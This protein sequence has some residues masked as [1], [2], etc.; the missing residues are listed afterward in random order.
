VDATLFSEPEATMPK[1][2]PK[3]PSDA[4]LTTFL[5]TL[6]SWDGATPSFQDIV[7][8]AATHAGAIKERHGDD[9]AFIPDLASQTNLAESLIKKW[10]AG[11]SLPNAKLAKTVVNEIRIYLERRRIPPHER[12]N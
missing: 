6:A 11:K 2:K 7:I 8:D 4:E 9:T 3:G 1:G 10:V 12:P 5:G